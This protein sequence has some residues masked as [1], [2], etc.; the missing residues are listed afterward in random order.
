MSNTA[1]I[2]IKRHSGM[3]SAAL[4][5]ARGFETAGLDVQLIVPT[6]RDVDNIRPGLFDG[7]ILPVGAVRSLT[8]PPPDIYVFD[9]AI[10]CAAEFER[11]GEGDLLNIAR[12]RFLSRPDSITRIFL[13]QYTL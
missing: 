5:L 11:F 9:D 10:R 4:A 7:A 8:L 6:M 3:T 2:I 13:F 1:T 12:N